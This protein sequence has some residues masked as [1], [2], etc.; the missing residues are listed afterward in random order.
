M[1]RTEQKTYQTGTP[2]DLKGE[3]LEVQTLAILIAM[4]SLPALLGKNNEAKRI[5]SQRDSL[6]PAEV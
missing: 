5:R 6:P 2:S 4:L 3:R 1:R